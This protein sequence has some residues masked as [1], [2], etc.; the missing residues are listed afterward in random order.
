MILGSGVDIVKVERFERW[1]SYSN[2]ALGKV[3]NI[4]E[5]EQVRE[6]SSSDRSPALQFLA[7][8]FAV[9]EALYKALCAFDPMMGVHKRPGFFLELARATYVTRTEDGVPILPSS[10]IAQFVF[11]D[12]VRASVSISHERCCSVATVTLFS[13]SMGV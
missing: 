5:I 3:F 13:S 12:S 8:R 11:S 2:H 1:L 4:R 7:S 9:K 10:V 6:F